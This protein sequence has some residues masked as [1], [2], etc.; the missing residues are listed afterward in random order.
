VSKEQVRKQTSKFL[1]NI[2]TSSSYRTYGQQEYYTAVADAGTINQNTSLT[3]A[4]SPIIPMQIVTMAG[5]S[6]IELTLLMNPE[7]LNVGR[8]FSTQPVYTRKGW[9]NQLWGPNPDTL[10]S[11]GKTAATMTP[12]VGL[13]NYLQIVSFSYLNL[14]SLISAYKNNGVEFLDQ[15]DANAVTRVVQLIHGIEICY[16]NHI[17]LGH[18]NNFSLDE[19][20]EHPYVFNY[21]FEFVVS[22]LSGSDQQIRGHYRQIPQTTEDM[23]S[24]TAGDVDLNLLL[25]DLTTKDPDVP[26]VAPK[27]TDDR[28]TER[29][30]IRKTGL[31]WSEAFD[32]GL[33]DGT[34][35]GNLRLR[36][37]ITSMQ[38]DPVNKKF[39]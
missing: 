34:V 32:L 7:V 28:T 33:T 2:Q 4:I 9:D 29:L 20:D 19:D 37:M 38:W 23:E 17:F 11:N 15:F 13:D 35:Q 10:S 39:Y 12:A 22:S 27:P 24:G 26:L 25:L 5:K 30:W 31:S 3:G 6:R 14:L 21:N 18:F 16:D 1:S 8:T 36:R